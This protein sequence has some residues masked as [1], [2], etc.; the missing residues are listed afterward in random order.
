MTWFKWTFKIVF[1]LNLLAINRNGVADWR[2]Q[3]QSPCRGFGHWDVML[4]FRGLEGY[5]H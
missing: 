1:A 4:E 2:V 3:I 5:S